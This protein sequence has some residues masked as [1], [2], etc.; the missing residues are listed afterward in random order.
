[1]ADI[2]PQDQPGKYVASDARASAGPEHHPPAP[3]A[4]DPTSNRSGDPS[5][6]HHC[7][8]AEYGSNDGTELPARQGLPE[9]KGIPGQGQLPAAVGDVLW[10]CTKLQRQHLVNENNDL[11]MKRCNARSIYRD[12]H[13]EQQGIFYS[14]PDLDSHPNN[15]LDI[16]SDKEEQGKPQCLPTPIDSITDNKGKT[17]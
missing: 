6:L 3:Y 10:Q 1:M 15:N 12:Q 8:G 13:Q 2:R 17:R 14:K 4:K 5:A 9:R 7:P 16:K 11:K